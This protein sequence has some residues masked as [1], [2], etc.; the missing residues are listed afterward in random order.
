M[1]Y[2]FDKTLL[3]RNFEETI[4]IVKAALKEEG[5]GIITE[6]DMKDTLKKKID[7]DYKQYT[8]LGACNPTFAYRALQCEDKIGVLLPCNVVVQ[9]KENGAVEVSA[10]NPNET[11]SAVH[12]E[13]LG[14]L[15]GEVTEKLMKV[16]ENLH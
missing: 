5:F 15:A 14:S 6:I 10:I 7:V 4:E 3:G 11:M 13:V 8:I 16:M 12:N 2:S 1:S 9:E